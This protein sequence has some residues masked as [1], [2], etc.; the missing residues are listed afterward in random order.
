MRHKAELERATQIRR[1]F[2]HSKL[3]DYETEIPRLYENFLQHEGKKLKKAQSFEEFLNIYYDDYLEGKANDFHKYAEKEIFNNL[4]AQKRFSIAT[5]VE[6]KKE[7]V[8][9]RSTQRK[10]VSDRPIRTLNQR[11]MSKG[12]YVDIDR[13]VITRRKKDVVI[14]R[15]SKGRF[16]KLI[17]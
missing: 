8:N 10:R 1:S 2:S 12:R 17:R 5:K 4:V 11:G 6:I 7:P 13:W 15:D 14:Y 16:S 9:L 3:I